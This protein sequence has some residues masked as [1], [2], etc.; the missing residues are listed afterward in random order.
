MA[1]DVLSRQKH[2]PQTQRRCPVQLYKLFRS[3][4]PEEMNKPDSPF[5]LAVRHGDRR[6]NPQIW[7]MKAPLGKNEIGKFLENSRR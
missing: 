3:H 6:V 4:R 2:M 1:T 7:Y 5:F